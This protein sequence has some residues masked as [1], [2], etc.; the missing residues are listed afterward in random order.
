MNPAHICVNLF[1]DLGKAELKSEKFDVNGDCIE[2]F[3]HV[4]EFRSEGSA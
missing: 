1:N 4:V 3:N 2:M